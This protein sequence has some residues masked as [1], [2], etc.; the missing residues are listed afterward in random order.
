[1]GTKHS[2]TYLKFFATLHEKRTVDGLG[3]TVKCSVW[4]IVKADGNAS[5]D[6][7][8]YSEIARQLNLNINIFF[9]LSEDIEK[10]SD[11]LT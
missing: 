9:L 6:A 1:M 2:N 3:G 4:R 10:K 8:S 7:M 11:Q 5:L